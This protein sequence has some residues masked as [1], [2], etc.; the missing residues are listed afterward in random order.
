MSVDKEC[1]G[2]GRTMLWTSFDIPFANACDSNP[3]SL[4]SSHVWKLERGSPLRS[5][6]L[7]N[8]A[9][10][11]LVDQLVDMLLYGQRHSS[12][13]VKMRRR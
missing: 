12:E 6:E 3:L 7:I 2:S 9:A 10:T 4:T 8:G 5:L 11:L 13:E 1:R